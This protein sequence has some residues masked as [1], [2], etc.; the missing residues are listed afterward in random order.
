[1][2]W[3]TTSQFDTGLDIGFLGD[4][5]TLVTDL[6]YKKTTDLL[7]NAPVPYT[8]GFAYSF[9][10]VGTL[11]NKGLEV[12]VNTVNTTRAVKWNSSFNIAF[13][14]NKVLNLNSDEGIPADPLLGINGWTSINAGSPIGTIYGYKTDGIIQLNEDPASVPGFVDYA[15][16][17]G[18][19]K[20]VDRNGD[21]VLTEADKFVLGNANPDFSFGMNHT[22]SYK[23]FS[24]GIFIQGVYGNDVV[25]FNKF[26][27]ESFDGN[28]NNSTAALERWTPENPTNKYPR[29]NVSPRVNTLSDH[30]VEDASYV[31]GERHHAF[32]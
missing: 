12:A 3:E 31:L 26:S 24:L 5:V 11:E 20:Y 10:N 27:L 4:R 19:S 13:N 6:Y 16:T 1:L 29:A 9:F 22:V 7:L 2:K 18:D 23:S 15:S 8:S 17:F 25:N 30:Q 32:L 21:G 28:Q 14:R